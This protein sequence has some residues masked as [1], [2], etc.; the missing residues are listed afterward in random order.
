MT[1][2]T[3]VH[4][5]A[6]RVG[7][8]ALALGAVAFLNVSVGA[9][10]A[11]AATCYYTGLTSTRVKNVDCG[12]GAYGYKASASATSATRVGAWVGPGKYSYNPN[13]ICYAYATMVKG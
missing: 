5:L 8:V 2:S 11:S 1:I 6:A 7:V 3:S 13:A 10:S 9:T 12:L 4:K